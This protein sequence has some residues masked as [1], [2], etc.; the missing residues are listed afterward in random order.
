MEV[1]LV[2]LVLHEGKRAEEGEGEQEKAA[3][4]IRRT[5]AETRT[6]D[7]GDDLIG[8]EFAVL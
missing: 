6:Y 8:N 3:A 5:R 4:C 7:V 1:R 2:R